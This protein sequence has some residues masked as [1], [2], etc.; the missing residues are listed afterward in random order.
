MAEAERRPVSALRS[1]ER[2]DQV[3]LISQ[4]QLRR[5]TRGDFYIAAFLSDS[6]GKINGR[7]N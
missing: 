6:T 3:F 7:K 5:T 1:A 4:P 2:I